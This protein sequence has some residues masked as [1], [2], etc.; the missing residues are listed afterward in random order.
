[1]IKRKES[2]ITGGLTICNTCIHKIVCSKYIACGEVN[3]CE[4]FKEDRKGRW[5]WA[6][7][8]PKTYLRKC[9]TCGGEAYFCGT[10]CGYKFCP[11][12][13]ADMRGKE[14]EKSE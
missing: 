7:T 6:N 5:L 8:R 9:S 12:C 2:G 4:H 1:M 3:K 14:D 11:N 13:G 10:G